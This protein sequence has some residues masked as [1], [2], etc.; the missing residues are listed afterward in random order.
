MTLVKWTP[1][2]RSLFDDMDNMISNVFEKDW[3]FPV[4]S[5][6]NWSPAVD[7]NESDSSFMLTA[8]IPGLTKK[9]VN[10]NVSN[11][12]LSISGERKIEDEKE[13]DNFHYRERLYGSFSRTFNL[14]ETVKEEDISASFKNGILSITLPKHEIELPKEREIKIN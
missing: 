13:S 10:V 6:S 9:E 8:D 14:P 1:R 5:K 3:N 12:V 4:Q 7:V 2:P 11:N